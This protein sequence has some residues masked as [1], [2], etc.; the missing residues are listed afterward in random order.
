MLP[1]P[2]FVLTIFGST[3]PIGGVDP[4][5]VRIRYA[6]GRDLFLRKNLQNIEE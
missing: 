3:P 4:N 6:A 2:W 1:A 5:M